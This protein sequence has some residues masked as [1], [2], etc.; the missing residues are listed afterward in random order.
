[1]NGVLVMAELLSAS[2]LPP[3]LQR[4]SDVIVKSGNGL[5]AIINDILDFSKIEAGKLELEAVP[6]SPREVIDDG[7]RLFAERAASKGLDLAGYVAR[8][9]PKTIAA[10]PIRLNQI[11]TNLLN[12]AIKFTATG[13]VSVRLESEVTIVDTKA[14]VFLKLSVTDTGVGIAEDKLDKIFESFSQADGSTTRSFG[15]TGIG[16]TICRRL[17]EAMGGKLTVTS[18][19]GKGSQF[20]ATLPAEVLSEAEQ[21]PQLVKSQAQTILLA[22]PASATRAALKE[23]A[24]DAGFLTRCIDPDNGP[25]VYANDGEIVFAMNDTLAILATPPSNVKSATVIA[26]SKMGDSPLHDSIGGIDI[27]SEIQYPICSSE[28]TRLLT[29]LAGGP[30]AL[31]EFVNS[32]SLPVRAEQNSF[33]GIHVLAA[34]DSAVNREV[35]LEALGRLQ[36][37]VTCVDNGQAAVAAAREAAFDLIFMDGSMPV[38]DGYEA[39]R[40]IREFESLSG[41]NRTPIVALTAHVI[42]DHANQWRDAGMDDCVTKPFTLDALESCLTKLVG[43]GSLQI[44]AVD[45]PRDSPIEQSHRTKETPAPLLDQGILLTIGEMQ[46][47]GNDLLSRVIDLYVK[48]APEAFD[49]LRQ[50]YHSADHKT[51]ATTAHALKS[52]SRNVGALRVGDQCHAIEQR[53]YA[54]DVNLSED[55]LNLLEQAVEATIN[56]LLDYR[57]RNELRAAS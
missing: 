52:L 23:Y 27:A 41:Q 28:L 54:G 51:I 11:L 53:A 17:V 29:A 16:L 40:K 10:D 9:V 31:A 21:E 24:D 42:G 57:E 18:Q 35:L 43:P 55:D 1:M 38:M 32:S 46:Q 22:L 39:T 6:V 3:R 30:E 34:D 25:A 7:L 33:A 12:N 15:G 36:V 8:Q 14:K 50:Q 5:L 44:E 26:I 20:L 49:Q 48:H 13:H 47:A 2:G 45:P 19:L 37:E 4:M 56:A